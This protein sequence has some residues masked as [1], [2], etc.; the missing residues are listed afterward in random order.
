MDFNI[1]EHHLAQ[2]LACAHNR[3]ENLKLVSTVLMRNSNHKRQN[4]GGG[5]ADGV[6]AFGPEG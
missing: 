4:S 6:A 1:N 3:R 2:V 5:Q